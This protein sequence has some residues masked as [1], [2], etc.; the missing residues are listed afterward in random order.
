MSKRQWYEQTAAEAIANLK[1]DQDAGLSVKEAA[2]RLG[3]G[4]RNRLAQ[5]PKRP[6]ILLFLDQFKDFM[7]MVLLAA[8]LVSGFIGDLAD[9]VTI[10]AIVLLNGFLGYI[11]T[12]KAEASLEKLKKL[13]APA[14]QVIRGGME[15]SVPGEELVRGILCCWRPV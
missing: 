4:G 9:T 10:L 2:L 1:S 5:K 7:V 15:I 14:A 13:A 11:Q 8:A 6:K 3:S 12:N